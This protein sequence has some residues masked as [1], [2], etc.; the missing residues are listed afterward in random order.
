MQDE[1]QQI[2]NILEEH[3]SG[4][5]ENTSEIQVL[6]EFLEEINLKVEQLSHRV[7]QLQLNQGKV[8]EKPL[9]VPL[10]RLEKKVFLLLSSEST[11]LSYGE[12]AAKSN[13]E[14]GL[15]PECISGL[16]SKGVPLQ[17][18]FVQDRFFFSLEPQFKGK[19]TKEASVHLSL[20]SFME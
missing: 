16:V 14:L 2:R 6:F 20:Q 7:E 11:P 15:V 18:T 19:Q 3:L 13:M 5:N 9:V 10:N 12:I 17:R 4:I 8:L 1:I